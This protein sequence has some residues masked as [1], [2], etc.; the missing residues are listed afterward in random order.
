MTDI[1][2]HQGDCIQAMMR[3]HLAADSV[4]CLV[5]SIPFGALFSY[6]HKPEDVGNT[7]DGEDFVASQFGLHMRW[8]FAEVERVM[9]P[10]CVVCIHVQQLNT[11][12][13]QH[14]HMGLRDFRGLWSLGVK[15]VASCC[16]HGK[17][18]PVIS[19]AAEHEEAML[20]LG[21]ERQEGVGPGAFVPQ[22]RRPLRSWQGEV[23]KRCFRRNCVGFHLPDDVW[24]AVV[25]GR[26]SLLC[27][28]CFDE[29]A[30][31]AGVA[32]TFGEVWPVEW[33]AWREPEDDPAEGRQA[34]T[35]RGR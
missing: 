7:K 15:T 22:F 2:L 3:D 29:L 30:D 25:A 10:G 5:T 28:T 24:S 21:Y 20:W 35:G 16:G 4:R 32:Y 13:L 9:S 33:S 11:T 14:G 34:G 17:A 12:Q 8:W 23:C 18:I 31:E 6:S 26:W 19:V 1:T 27:T